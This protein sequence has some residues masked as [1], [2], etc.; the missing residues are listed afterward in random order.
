MNI[1]PS[2]MIVAANVAPMI[3]KRL[4]PSSNALIMLPIPNIGA[5]SIV[6]KNKPKK[7]CIWYTSFVLRVIRDALDILFN[8]KFEN[9]RIF[10]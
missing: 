9:F 8:S 5:N 4:V 7:I 10:S 3:H 2:G 6:V 1:N